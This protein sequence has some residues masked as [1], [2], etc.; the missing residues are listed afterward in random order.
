VFSDIHNSKYE[1]DAPMLLP[2]LLSESNTKST[3]IDIPE[4]EYEIILSISANHDDAEHVCIPSSP[5][6]DVVSERTLEKKQPQS[7]VLSPTKEEINEELSSQVSKEEQEAIRENLLPSK[8]EISPNTFIVVLEVDC[9]KEP[10][11]SPSSENSIRDSPEKVR[12]PE[13]TPKQD[14]SKDKPEFNPNSAVPSSS[15][16]ILKIIINISYF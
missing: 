13:V 15:G 9:K 1:C 16:N 11:P 5:L 2:M 7:L 8:E 10:E 6:P 4:D 12:E 3:F 14:D